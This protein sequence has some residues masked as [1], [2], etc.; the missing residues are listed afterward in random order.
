MTYHKHLEKLL[1]SRIVIGRIIFCLSTKGQGCLK[2]LL[3]VFCIFLSGLFSI[4]KQKYKACLEYHIGRCMAPC[5]GKQTEAAYSENIE[6]VKAIIKGNLAEV[7]RL[8]Q[9]QMQ[10]AADAYEFEA[11]QKI[12]ER[13]EMLERYQVKSIIVNPSITNVDIFSIIVDNREAYC[14]FLRVVQGAV[15]QSHTV[16][17]RMGIEEERESLLSYFIAEMRSRLGSLSKQIIVPFLPDHEWPDTAYIV[18]QR[19]DKQKLL[20]LSERNCRVFKLEKLKQLEKVHPEKHTERILSAVQRDLNLPVLPVHIE[21]FDNSNIQGA[22]PV[23]SCVVFKNAKPSK[24]DYRH[25][26]VKTVEGP[27]DFAT[28]F[29]VITR[30]YRRLLEEEQPLPQLIVV[31]G[32]KGQLSIAHE[33]LTALKL[34]D[35]ITMIS[36]AERLEEI[37]F[38][39]DSVPLFLDKNATTLRLLM[40]MRD[41]AHRFGITHHRLRRSKALTT[42]ELTAI[43]GIGKATAEK[44]LIAFKSVTRI[45]AATLEKI[46]EVVGKKAAQIIK[47]YFAE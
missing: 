34:E 46:Q 6:A 21:C 17:L 1:R 15:V 12:K 3:S 7:K 27:N 35:K 5:E 25:F 44:L 41:E 47:D 10:R 24:K 2:D 36:L 20:E 43:D 42:T 32:G 26:N 18:P 39:G 13:L 9:Q 23:S 40:Q 30:R 38:V 29:E 28:M 37:Y 45:K 19:G 14:N 22:F 4:A 31:D 16:E 11:A 33:A 8:L